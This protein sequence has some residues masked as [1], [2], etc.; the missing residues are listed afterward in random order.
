MCFTGSNG[1][2]VTTDSLRALHACRASVRMGG[3]NTSRRGFLLQSAAGM[4]ALYA[5][6]TSPDIFEAAAAGDTA[7]IT[8]LLSADP[9]AVRARSADGRT[10]LHF[11]VAA[12][13]AE[14][15]T[16]LGT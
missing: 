12:G 1:V 8:E 3:M 13:K 16:L 14:A 10:P 6:K 4:G 7:R 15:V 9:M 5:Q 2:R 11:A